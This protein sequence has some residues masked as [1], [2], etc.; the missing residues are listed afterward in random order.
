V[1]VEPKN[2]LE[3]PIRQTQKVIFSIAT[4]LFRD[5]YFDDVDGLSSFQTSED[6]PAIGWAG[7]IPDFN[8]GASLSASVAML[9]AAAA[10]LI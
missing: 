2:K 3:V 6:V 5:D 7:P 9:L 1:F 10:L 8:S 4:P